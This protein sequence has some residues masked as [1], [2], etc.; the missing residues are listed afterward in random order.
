MI[1]KQ[2]GTL[3]IGFVISLANS[4]PAHTQVQAAPGDDHADLKYVVYVTRHGVRS[5]TGKV[6]QYSQYSTAPWPAWDV[7]PGYLTAHGFQLMQIFGS[8]DRLLLHDEGLLP[9]SG[10]EA[11]NQVT[12]YADSDERTRETGR[13]LAASLLPGCNVTVA[14]LPEGENDPLFHPPASSISATAW[15]EAAIAGRIGND[16]SAISEAYRSKLLELDNVLGSCGAHTGTAPSRT[17]IVDIPASL[18]PGSGDHAVDLHGPLN[19]ASTLTEILLLEYAQGMPANDVGWGC[20]DGRKVRSLIDLHTA[21][22][23]LTQRTPAVAA[24]QASNLLRTIANSMK[25]AVTR[26]AVPHVP[27]RTAD[28]ALLLVGHDTNLS[29]LAGLLDINWLEDGRRDDTPPGST[30]VFELWQS[31]RT[32]EFSVRLFF[33]AQ[34]LE[35]MRNSTVLSMQN[36]PQR[37]PVFVPGCSRADFSCSWDAFSQTVSRSIDEGSLKAR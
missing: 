1:L 3:S 27:G 24:L 12:I 18:T 36:P 14:G 25:Q 15:A 37:V 23:D 20:V 21:A 28:R 10:C 19:T 5:P 6:S 34:T 2:L 4:L 11:A 8:Y 13:A 33:M 17:S 35:Q 7:A 22:S 30:L 31:Q 29:N 32:K 16:P 9:A 26:Q